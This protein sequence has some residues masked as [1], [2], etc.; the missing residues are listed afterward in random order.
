MKKGLFTF[1][2]CLGMLSISFAQSLEIVSHDAVSEINSKNIM[3]YGAHA[4]V[5]NI[6]NS[7]VTVLVKRVEF[8]QTWCAFDSNYFCWD[9]CY[10]NST[11][12]SI[13]GWTL[14]PGEVSDPS[15]FSAHVYSKN[16]GSSCEDSIR[17]V[18]FVDTDPNDSVSV[19]FKFASGPTMSVNEVEQNNS[20]FYPNPASNL[21]F[22]ELANTPAPNTTI[23]VY[24]ILGAKMKTVDATSAK[25]EINI[26]DLNAGVY[27]YTVS[28][29]GTAVETKKF[30]VKK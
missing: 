28:E 13:G 20:T 1:L 12:Y 27:I 3:D 21:L 18:F 10:G 8:G 29:N 25:T 24:S 26:S 23:E 5:K 6:S 9:L 2:A 16:D 7:A 11:N 14:A 17:Y 15:Y 19:V 30:V 4:E 22:V